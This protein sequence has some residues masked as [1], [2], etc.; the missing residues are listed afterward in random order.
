ML[1]ILTALFDPKFQPP[2]PDRVTQIKQGIAPTTE[3]VTI[4]PWWFWF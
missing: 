3:R 1:R 2:A 4:M